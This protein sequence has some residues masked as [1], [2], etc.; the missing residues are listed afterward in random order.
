VKATYSVARIAP[1]E[2]RAELLRLW[3]DNLPLDGPAERK[4]DWIYRDA[5]DRPDAVFL[6]AAEQDGARRWVGTAGVGVRRIWVQGTERRAGL[7]A[8]LAVDRDH[9]SVMPALQL[10]RAARG[11]VLTEMDLAY[12]FPNERAEGVFK[13]VGYRPLG[14]IGRWARVLRHA[15]YAARVK[16]RDLPVPPALKKM[17]DRA[18]EVPALAAL[19]GGA[20]DAVKLAQGAP[21]AVA[22]VRRIKLSWLDAP[23]DRIDAVWEDARVDHEVVGVRSSRLLRWRFP[24]GPAISIALATARGDDAP[25]AYA[26]IEQL[27]GVAHVRDLFGRRESIGALLDLLIPALYPRGASSISVRYLG[28]PW[29]I[30][31][32]ESRGWVSRDSAR[33]I[34]IGVR[35]GLG[36]EAQAALTDAAR[37]HL[38]DFDEDT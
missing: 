16:E 12:G 22:A 21:A 2:A 36:A 38:T 23:D 7:L 6:L 17:V 35:D 25:V 18:A 30:A 19:A 34:T 14:T 1:E 4:F 24:P 29:L 3:A 37:W 20:Y 8:D 11:F 5:P 13:R 15:S 26:V 33:L 10:V 31:E 28:A 27:D 9:R 32:L